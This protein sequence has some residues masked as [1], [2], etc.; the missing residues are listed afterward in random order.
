MG[1]VLGQ[2]LGEQQERERLELFEACRKG[3]IFFLEIAFDEAKLMTGD[4]IFI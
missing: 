2:C 1:L 3:Y 4:V